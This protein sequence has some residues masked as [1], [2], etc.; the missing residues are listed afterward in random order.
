[1]I[2]ELIDVC[3]LDGTPTGIVKPRSVIH[4]GDK[5]WHRTSAVLIIGP[6]GRYLAHQR[7]LTKQM[8]AGR[9]THNFGGHVNAGE[10]PVE[11]S[12]RELQEE[13]GINVRVEALTFKGIQCYEEP[14][15]IDFIFEY[16]YQPSD[17]LP[18]PSLDEVAQVKWIT[19]EEL[20][21][22]SDTGIFYFPLYD[23]IRA[24]FS[25]AEGTAAL[26]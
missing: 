4:A 18:S 8:H 26:G 24:Q 6:D 1:M 16:Q 22:W 7:S 3:H 10:T 25:M 23:V 15:H 19:A 9:W 11:N 21:Q 12:V 14:K 17:G 2:E 20:V 13:I 5:E